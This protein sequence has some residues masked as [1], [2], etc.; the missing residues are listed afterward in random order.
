MSHK[1]RL[2]A[3]EIADIR[4][5]AAEGGAPYGFTADQILDEAIAFLQW[6]PEDQ[7]RQF[8]GY[9]D[10]E[11]CALWA[12]LPLYRLARRGPVKGRR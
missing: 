2:L 7:K 9:S 4:S 1:Q 11:W 3:L 12:R 6:P 10:A 8:P 5:M